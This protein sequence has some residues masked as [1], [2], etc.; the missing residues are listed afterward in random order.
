MNLKDQSE[1]EGERKD[2][3]MLSIKLLLMEKYMCIE[4]H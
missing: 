4:F 3:E 1:R 2:K